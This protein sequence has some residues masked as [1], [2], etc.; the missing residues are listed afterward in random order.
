MGRPIHAWDK[1]YIEYLRKKSL[2]GGPSL[3]CTFTAVDG[4]KALRKL[5]TLYDPQVRVSFAERMLV[6]SQLYD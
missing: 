4:Q 3:H 1:P 5:M 6:L 2:C